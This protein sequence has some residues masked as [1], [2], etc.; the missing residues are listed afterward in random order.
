MVERGHVDYVFSE[1]ESTEEG[2]E[3]VF[4]DAGEYWACVV[5][6]VTKSPV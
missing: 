5:V 2:E 3:Q 6:V 4:M 1:S